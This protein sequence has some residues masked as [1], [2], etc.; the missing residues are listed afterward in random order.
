MLA[1]AQPVEVAPQR[2]DLAGDG[3]ARE[4]AG[5]Q[6]C[7]VAPQHQTVDSCGPVEAEPLGP[8][9]ETGDVTAVRERGVVG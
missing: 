5:R 1:A 2:G 7:H 8:L 9:D 4:L 6:R 3:A